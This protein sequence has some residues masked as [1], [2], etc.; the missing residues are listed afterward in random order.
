MLQEELNKILDLHELWV[1]GSSKGK[2]ADLSDK[3][4]SGLDFS[5]RNLI[6]IIMNK[7]NLSNAKL[8]NA[9]FSHANLSNANLSYANL[10]YANLSKANL[11]KANLSF[12]NLSYASLYKANLSFANLSLADLSE[13]NLSNA[14]ISGTN[15]YSLRLSGSKLENLDFSGFN[16]CPEEGQFYGYKKVKSDFILKLLI[17]KNAKRLNPIGYRQCRASKVKVIEAYNP[18]GSKTD[19]KLFKSFY[20]PNFEYEVGKW[21]EVKNFNDDIRE[22]YTPGIHFFLTKKEAINYLL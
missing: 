19:Q 18:D 13:A 22:V 21:A 2:K 7:A 16:I 9:N 20:D 12:A 10:S 14:K 17:S 11:F 8:W 6:R 4:L 3:D 5:N 15:F 1:K